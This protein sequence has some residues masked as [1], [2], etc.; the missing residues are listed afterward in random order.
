MNAS[1]SFTRCGVLETYLSHMPC[2]IACASV[3][4]LEGLLERAGAD[5]EGVLVVG[6]LEA[7]VRCLGGIVDG[8]RRVVS[9]GFEGSCS[10]GV[11]AEWA[12]E[13]R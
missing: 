10:F 9:S 2:R 12:W 8:G 13:L 3:L 1:S 11:E 6:A 4:W 5:V 7:V